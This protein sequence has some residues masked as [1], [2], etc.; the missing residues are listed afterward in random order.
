[1]PCVSGTGLCIGMVDP[2]HDMDTGKQK[3]ESVFSS[4]QLCIHEK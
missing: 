3:K 2:S 4:K 1:M